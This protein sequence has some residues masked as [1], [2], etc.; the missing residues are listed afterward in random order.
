[1]HKSMGKTIPCKMSFGDCT[2][3][4]TMYKPGE[5]ETQ[6]Y[7]NFKDLEVIVILTYP[8]TL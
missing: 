7:L 2:L 5:R 6:L 3:T 4:S 8:Q 1:M